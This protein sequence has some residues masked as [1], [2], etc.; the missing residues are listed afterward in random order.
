MISDRYPYS[1]YFGVQYWGILRYGKYT[2]GYY[3]LSVLQ[4]FSSN[5]RYF[6]RWYCTASPASTIVLSI[7]VLKEY[8][9]LNP[10][11]TAVPFWG[12]TT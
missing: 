6:I 11:R 1:Q 10:F 9:V 7:I 2:S 12:Q 3:I 8:E 5:W 4:A